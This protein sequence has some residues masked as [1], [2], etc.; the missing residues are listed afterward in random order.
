MSIDLKNKN[1][2]SPIVLIAFNRINHFKQTLDALVKNKEAKDS[3]LY[4]CIDGPRNAEDKKNQDQMCDYVEI[5]Q[6]EF[7]NVK[8][9]KQNSNLGLAKHIIQ[10]VT[11]IVNQHGK[12]IV[13]EDD[14]CVSEAFLK[15]MNDA[16]TYYEPHKKVWH[17]ASHT[18]VNNSKKEN[19]VFLYR[20]MNCWGWATWKDRWSF[21]EKDPEALINEF[22]NEDIKKFNLDDT[23]PFWSQVLNNYSGHINTWAIFWY[24]TIF[25]NKGL[26]M[27]PFYSYVRNIG[28]DGSGVHKNI[29][30][31]LQDLQV[32]NNDGKFNPQID[33]EENFLA[34]N[35][36]KKY[37]LN[38][39][40]S[41]KKITRSLIILFLNRRLLGRLQNLWYRIRN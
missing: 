27:N 7:Q 39:L 19:E 8:I 11:N 20:V 14:H 30:K 25:K 6:N 9:I 17:I 35:E 24:A 36:I 4:V 32:I 2:L 23:E 10:S 16:L 22:T 18:I 38:N 12:L 28:L 21:F 37:Y 40:S 29:N 13:L 1:M 5:I 34:V 3:M 15:F 33:I 31:K 26:C 41:L